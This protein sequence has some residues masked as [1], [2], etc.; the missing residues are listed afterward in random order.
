MFFMTNISAEVTDLDLNDFAKFQRRV[1]FRAKLFKDLKS[2][3]RKEYLGL[4]AQKRSKPISH[5]MKV[6]EIVLVENPNK[7]RLYWPLAKVLDL[8]PGRNGNI[9]TLKLKCGNAEIIRPVPRLF[10]LEI[11][12][13][14]LPIAAVGMERVPEPSNLT[15]IRV[16][17][18]DEEVN[19]ELTEVT[20]AMDSCKFSRCRRKIKPPQKLD[21]LNLT[22]FFES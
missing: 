7:K 12:P 14:E 11:Q 4:L 16:A 10:L 9:R 18:T 13:E 6:G 8:L 19:P 1:R 2:R 15:E 17:Y 22:V 3:F 21:L 20:P 5:K